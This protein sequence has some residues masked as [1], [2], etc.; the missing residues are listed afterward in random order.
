MQLVSQLILFLNKLISPKEESV[1]LF[2]YHFF[3]LKYYLNPIASQQNFAQQLNIS[4]EK[5]NLISL[6]YYNYSFEFLIN[7]KRYQHFLKEMQNPLHANL[8]VKS[9]LQSCGFGSI[10]CFVD[11]IDNRNKNLYASS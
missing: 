9:I 8:T 4:V 1:H 11:F 6:Y 10:S 3:D 2:K 7:E 5:L